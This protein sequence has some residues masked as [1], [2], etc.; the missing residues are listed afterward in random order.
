MMCAIHNFYLLYAQSAQILA[1]VELPSLIR[2]NVKHYISCIGGAIQMHEY[3]ELMKAAGFKG[4]Q[5]HSPPL[6]VL[7]ESDKIPCSWTVLRTS[8]SI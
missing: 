4:A 5:S 7:I 3:N 6:T 1:K 8:T 2:D